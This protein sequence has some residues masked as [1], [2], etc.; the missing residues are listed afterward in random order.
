MSEDHGI[1]ADGQPSGLEHR[2][3]KSYNFGDVIF[4]EGSRLPF[5]VS[6]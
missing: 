3:M 1:Q 2:F 4:E 5:C 6:T